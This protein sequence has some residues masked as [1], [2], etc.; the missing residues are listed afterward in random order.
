MRKLTFLFMLVLTF[1]AGLSMKAQESPTGWYAPGERLDVARITAGTDVFIYSMCYVN[2]DASSNSSRFI[3]NNGNRAT[4]FAGSPTSLVT[5]TLGHMWR[6]RSVENV[7]RTENVTDSQG[8]ETTVTYTGTQLTFSRNKGSEATTYYWGIGGVTNNDRAGDAQKFVLT[9]WKTQEPYVSG[10]SKSGADVH[11]EDAAGNIIPQSSLTDDDYVYLMCA[12]SGKA[13]N[14]QSGAYQTNLTNGYPVALYSV[15]EVPVPADPLGFHVSAAPTTTDGVTVWNADTKW[16]KLKMNSSS[17]RYVETGYGYTNA[18]DKLTINK[19]ASSNLFTGAWAVVGDD[20]NGYQFYNMGEGPSKVLG[21]TGSEDGARTSMVDATNPGDGVTTTFDITYHTDGYWYIKKHGTPNE[22]INK[23]DPY[24]GLWNSPAGLGNPGS[25]FAFE[26][27]DDVSAY[28]TAA[29]TKLLGR[30]GMWKKVPAIWA[31]ASAAYDALNVTLSATVTNA[32]LVA[33]ATAQKTAGAAFVTAVNNQRFTASNR[34]NATAARIGAFMYMDNA[35][36]NKLKGRTT[37]TATMDEVFTLKTNSDFTFKIYNANV[38]K[39]VGKPTNTPSTP[40][41]VVGNAPDFDLFTDNGFAD[42]VVI[43]CINGTATMHLYNTLSVG[44]YSSTS[45][46]ASRWLLSNDVSRY[47]LNTAIVNATTWKN[48]LETL[49]SNLVTAKKISVKPTSLTVTLPVA[50]TKAQSAFDDAAGT[51]ATRTAAATALNAALTKAQS[52]WLGEFGTTQQFRLKNH[53]ITTETTENEVTTTTNFYLTMGQ[54][55]DSNNEGNA[56]LAAFDEN[57]VNQIFTLVPGTGNNAGKYILVSDGKQ[58]TDL[59]DWNTNMTDAGTPYTFVEVDLAN[60][61]FRVRTTKGL[62]GPNDGVT[63]ASA[64]KII[65]TN[66]TGTRDNLTWELEFIAPI[67]SGVDKQSLQDTYEAQNFVK[68]NSLNFVS[69]N[70]PSLTAYTAIRENA[71]HVINGTTGKTVTQFDVNTAE[72]ELKAAYQQML[73]NFVSEAGPTQGYLLQYYHPTNYTA[74]DLYLTFNTGEF[75]ETHAVNALQLKQRSAATQQNAQFVST[76]SNNSF[77]IREGFNKKLVGESSTYN[78]NPM[79]KD[80]GVAYTIELVTIDGIDGLVARLHNQRGYLGCDLKGDEHPAVAANDYLYTNNSENN[81]FILTP[82]VSPDVVITLH[83]MIDRARRYEAHMGTGLGKYTN[84]AGMNG[85][86]L[87]DLNDLYTDMINETGSFEGQ[88]KTTSGVTAIINDVYN[89]MVFPFTINKPTAG[90]LYRFKGK[91]SGKYM[92][93]TST[94]QLSMVDDYDLPG[95]I[96]QL[97]EGAQIDGETGYKFL[98]YNTG[99]YNKDTYNNDAFAAAANSF[100]IYQ[101]EDDNLT[102]YTLK[103]NYSGSKYVFDNGNLSSPIVDRNSGYVANNC[104]WTIEEVTWLPVPI[105]QTAKFGTFC[106]PMPLAITDNTYYSEGTRIIFYTGAINGESGNLD[107]TRVTTNIPANTPVVTQYVAHE[108]YKHG[109]AYL[110]IAE[111]AD[112]L[113]GSNDLRGTLETINK[114]TDQGSIYTLQRPAGKPTGFYLHG[115]NTVKGCRAYLPIA[116]GLPAPA[117]FSFNFGTATGIDEVSVENR[118]DVIYDLSGRRVQK[119]TN[120]L[121]IINGKKVLVK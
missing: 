58:L 106:S 80:N 101:S 28:A 110:K 24:V 16:Y 31:N 112:A 12:L 38:D 29:H 18:S 71:E 91:V 105:S 59:G 69:Q 60:S 107:L 37:S 103:S 47:E 63:G 10:T 33:A 55:K 20:T 108:G 89:T 72:A 1:A 96:F 83:N 49:V 36:S 118:N 26:A 62:L 76:G 90:K 19:T 22:Y 73:A 120:G 67:F 7:S 3:V 53:A 82:T 57:D 100:R 111:S 6:V 4:T 45:D 99:Y 68:N 44:N 61:L 75:T 46:M 17:W 95:T 13:I 79:L 93:A 85:T 98:S 5:K 34:D 35:D 113:A 40:A 70:A 66:H 41:V 11:L 116:P 43:F 32:E 84:P 52:A 74:K 65:Y 81:Y 114:P 8:H 56:I 115:G 94:G 42:N 92:C 50:L 27:I 104:D 102:Y 30:V 9:K 87:K 25:C 51:P 78:W 14:T 77:Y 119:A 117:G 48:N 23:R 15:R 121:Y 39:Y 86:A 21:V 88:A 97:S 54:T 109:C 2:G 64:S